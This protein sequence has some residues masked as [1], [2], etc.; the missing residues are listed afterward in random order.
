MTDSDRL[1][2]E[3]AFDA[4][5]GAPLDPDLLRQIASDPEAAS[6]WDRLEHLRALA[7][8]HD[9]AAAVPVHAPSI[10]AGRSSPLGQRSAL[11]ASL[12][13]AAAAAA[14]LFVFQL[15]RTV[16]IASRSA[17]VRHAAV[18]L[19]DQ[20][21]AER[22][23]TE[24]RPTGSSEVQ[25][26]RWANNDLLDAGTALRLILDRRAPTRRPSS[27]SEI[28]AIRLANGASPRATQWKNTALGRGL[29][30]H[31][32]PRATPRRDTEPDT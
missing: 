23:S 7:R 29:A 30:R 5:P 10:R 20:S 18:A 26:Y 2:L 16:P 13:V 15:P 3:Q 31:E 4:G 8:R 1:R 21:I 19:T 28:E 9:P 11:W 22:R 24:R 27:R 17:P 32:P 25:L 12:A 6:Y 14:V